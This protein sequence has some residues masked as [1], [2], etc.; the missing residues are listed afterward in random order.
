MGLRRLRKNPAYSGFSGDQYYLGAEPN[1][2][3]Y[4]IALDRHL[5]LGADGR[6]IFRAYALEHWTERRRHC[7]RVFENLLHV[8]QPGPGQILRRLLGLVKS[9]GREHLWERTGGREAKRI[10]SSRRQHGA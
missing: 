2:I 1:F 6:V 4:A 9:G 5:H 7:A 10:G 3:P 8:S